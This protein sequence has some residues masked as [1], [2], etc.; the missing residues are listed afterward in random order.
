MCK[1][2]TLRRKNFAVQTG[3]AEF[4]VSM[5]LVQLDM[6][7]GKQTQSLFM[8]PYASEQQ[9]EIRRSAEVL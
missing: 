5:K 1:E 9:D 2:T 8:T 7:T 3:C 4:S 6:E